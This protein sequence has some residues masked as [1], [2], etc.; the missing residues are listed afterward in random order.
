MVNFVLRDQKLFLSYI[1]PY[2][3]VILYT[4]LINILYYSLIFYIYPI[5]QSPYFLAVL[6]LYEK[7]FCSKVFRRQKAIGYFLKSINICELLIR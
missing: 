7:S 6:R 3:S 1:Y 4:K 5:F 2:Y